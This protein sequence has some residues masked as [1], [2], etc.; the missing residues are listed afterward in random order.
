MKTYNVKEVAKLM[1]TS[2]ET[3]RRWI[4][5]GKLKAS[6]ESRK[7]GI[8]ITE[9]MLEE[10]AKGMPKYATA[11]SASMGGIIATSTLW[12]G[13]I[14][15]S[16]IMHNSDIKKSEVAAEEIE[17]LLKEKIVLSKEMIKR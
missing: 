8:I 9:T 2:E 7:K 10:F 12:L 13:S 4:R 6:M 14:M 11:L 17:K 3:V 16:S 5:D 15:A 1:N